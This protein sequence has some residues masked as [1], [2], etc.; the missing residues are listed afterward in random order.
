MVCITNYWPG[1][2]K[3]CDVLHSDQPPEELAGYTG[4]LLSYVMIPPAQ[5]VEE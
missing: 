4:F 3:S 2:L 1:K 5:V